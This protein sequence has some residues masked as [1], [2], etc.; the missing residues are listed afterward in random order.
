MPYMGLLK[1]STQVTKTILMVDTADH[2]TGKTGLT[3]T[4]Y[5]T[6]A[7]GTPTSA[8]MT[9][10]ELDSTNAKGIYS[11]VFSTSH[12]DTLGDFQ[13]HLSGTGADPSDY[14]W[15][16]VA[17]LNDDLAYPVTSG[18]S[19]VVDASGL[20]DANTVKVGPTGSGSAQTARDIG[21]SV[22]LSSGTGTGQLDFTSGVVKANL[23]QILGTALTETA[24]QIAAAFKKFFDKAT[25]TGTINSL[26]DAVPGA[27]GGLLIDDVWTDAR[28]AKLDNL[29]ATVSSRLASASYTAPDNASITAI[30]VKTDNLPSDPADASDI[31]SS[32][33]TVNTKL[34]TIDDF[35][36]TEVAAIKLKTDNLP[37]DPA[38]ASD[39]AAAFAVTDGKIDTVDAVADAI[40][41]KTDSLTFTVTN[42]VNANVQ[43]INDTALTGDGSGTP[44]GPA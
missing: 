35:L 14:W 11:L 44:W 32:F 3:I 43:S 18:R 20:V 40:K 29:D 26:P 1:Q 23:A 9:T 42:E 19:M 16:V 13:L 33:T 21:A 38:D 10:S 39:I 8:T 4:K 27:A 17:R 34:D 25:P 28:A 15:T 7:G 37:S 24:G 12:T 22:L 6:K 41:V 5:L 30:K 31:A 2:I 36:D